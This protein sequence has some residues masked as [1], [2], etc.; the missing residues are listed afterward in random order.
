M[1]GSVLCCGGEKLSKVFTRVIVYVLCWEKTTGKQ[2]WN[3]V[4]VC[5]CVGCVGDV[6]GMCVW[7]EKEKM[8]CSYV[9]YVRC[10]DPCWFSVC[11]SDWIAFRC[12]AMND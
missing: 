2:W 1:M 4:C 6:C 10:D 9:W 11:L 8:G 7:G 5:V 3:K 12:F